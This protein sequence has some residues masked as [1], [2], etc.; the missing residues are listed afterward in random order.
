MSN[1]SEIRSDQN[2]ADRNHD[3]VIRLMG[4]LNRCDLDTIRAILAPDAV[5]YVSGIGTLDLE[6]LLAQL[7][8]MLSVAAVARTTIVATTS[9]GERVAVE[10]RG[11]FEFPDG[12]AYRNHYH[13]L[14]TIRGD[15][16]VGVREYLDLR[17]TER[18]FGPMGGGA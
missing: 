13:H 14:F 9:E 5:W 11:N 17:E 4:A 10:S 15:R 1:A 2:L 7:Q 16:V 6:T 3:L 18:V 12:R 8:Q